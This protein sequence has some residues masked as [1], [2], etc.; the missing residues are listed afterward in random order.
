MQLEAI[1]GVLKELRET[2]HKENDIH[3][4]IE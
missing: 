3:G 4:I 1:N 2:I